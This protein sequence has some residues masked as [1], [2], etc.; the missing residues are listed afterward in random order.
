MNRKHSLL[1]S[2][3]FAFRGI[4]YAVR[5]E[6]NLRIHLVAAAY[7]LFLSRLYRLDSLRLLIVG[8]AIAMVLSLELVNTAI[9][10]SADIKAPEYHPLAGAAKDVAA[11]AVLVSAVFSVFVGFII[12]W[13][14]VILKGLLLALLGSPLYAALFL[15]SAVLSFLFIRGGRPKR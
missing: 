10:K 9:E 15:L 3:R 14:P 11:A 6:R 12:F 7:M 1:D 8:A 13:N 4:C 5:R 2:F